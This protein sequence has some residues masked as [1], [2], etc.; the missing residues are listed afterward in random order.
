[1]ANKT[2]REAAKKAHVFLWQLADELGI[3]E[4]GMTRL[5]RRQLDAETEKKL[6]ILIDEIAAKQK[7][8]E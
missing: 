2:I 6:L 8:A 3:S 7:A 4:M 1:M 5:L